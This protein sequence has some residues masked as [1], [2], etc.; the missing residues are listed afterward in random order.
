MFKCLS[1]DQ[2][3]QISSGIEKTDIPYKIADIS[4][5]EF[6]RK[7]IDIA[8]HEMPGLMA[9]RESTLQKSRWM[10]CESLD[11]ST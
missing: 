4:D 1:I 7:E 9:I 2:S 8:E 11:H 10:G 5:A 3:V 6:G